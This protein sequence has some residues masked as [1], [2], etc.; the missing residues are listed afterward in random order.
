MRKLGLILLLLLTIGCGNQQNEPEQMPEIIVDEEINEDE[1]IELDDP[2][3]EEVIEKIGVP[4]PISGIY[5]PEE[6][7]SVRPIA[8]VLDNHP[9]SR[10]QAGIQQAE[11]VYE[12]EVEGP[13]T[14]YLAIYLTESP[15]HIGPVRSARPYFL[16]FALEFDAVFVHVGGS[17]EALIK[18]RDYNMANISGMTSGEFWRYYDTGKEAPNNM[19]TAMDNLRE[20][21]SYMNFRQEGNYESWQFHEDF[22]P[23]DECQETVTCL[24]F[25]IYYN[26]EYHVSYDYD[27]LLRTYRRFV[28]G[29]EHMD[30]LDESAVTVTNIIIQKVNKRVLDSV[31]RLSLDTLSTGEGYYVTGGEVMEITWEKSS[32]REKTAYY[33]ETGKAL[34][35]NPGKTWVQIVS[36]N[37]VIEIGDEQ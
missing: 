27:E 28:N 18:I 11:I 13:Y 4:S 19:Y 34:V 6:A 16:E 21:Q 35:L 37:T 1:H 30:E 9:A 24:S 29:K 23:M 14:R 2:N 36:Q 25:A 26:S 10:W 17:D 15:E 7:T 33:D 8:V 22:T 5:Y 32:I 20:A 3:E 12:C 31:G